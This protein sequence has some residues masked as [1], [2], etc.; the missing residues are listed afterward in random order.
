MRRLITSFVVATMAF[1][2]S[3]G[4][5]KDDPLSPSETDLNTIR[6]LTSGAFGGNYTTSLLFGRLVNGEPVSRTVDDNQIH[7]YELDLK[8][9]GPVLIT[10]DSNDP[11]IGVIKVTDQ[12]FFDP[13][14]WDHESSNDPPTG[15]D[16]RVFA[17]RNLSKGTYLIVVTDYYADE[18]AYR[19]L[20]E[21]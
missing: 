3:C 6:S 5:D 13:L 14:L 1:C 21:W 19:L 9:T 16:E 7:L 11:G 12:G 10:L 18:E 17:S 20:V 8:K 2:T 15:Y 4:S